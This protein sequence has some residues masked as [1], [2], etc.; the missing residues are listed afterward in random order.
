MLTCL[1]KKDFSDKYWLSTVEVDQRFKKSVIREESWIFD[2]T[3]GHLAAN[4]NP[5]ELHK[6]TCHLKRINEKLV[7]D[8]YKHGDVSPLHVAAAKVDDS[9]STR[10]ITKE[11]LKIQL[12]KLKE[13]NI[14]YKTSGFLMKFL[15]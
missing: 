14:F 3:C 15:F 11:I 2:A 1:L 13:Q 8:I 9:R 6:M 4:F 7:I 5:K 12:T 10:Y